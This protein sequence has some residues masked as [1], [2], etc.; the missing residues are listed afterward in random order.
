MK[1]EKYGIIYKITNKVNGKLYIGQTIKKDGFNGRYRGRGEGIERVWNTYKNYLNGDKTRRGFNPHLVSAIRKYGFDAFIVEEEFDVAYSQEE[2]NE[3][4][5]YWIEYYNSANYDKGYNISLG[6]ELR[7]DE[8]ENTIAAFLSILSFAKKVNSII[9]Y[10]VDND[11]KITLPKR[12]CGYF[13]YIKD[14][15]K[16]IKEGKKVKN[17]KCCGKYFITK[18]STCEKCI[19]VVENKYL[20]LEDDDIVKTIKDIIKHKE[21]YLDE[22]CDGIYYRK[23]IEKIEKMDVSKGINFTDYDIEIINSFKES[24]RIVFALLVL[25][26]INKEQETKISEVR[27]LIRLSNETNDYVKQLISESKYFLVNGNNFTVV[28]SQDEK[29]KFAIYTLENLNL[30]YKYHFKYDQS[31]YDICKKCKLPYKKGKG[32]KYCKS[33]ANRK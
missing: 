28:K 12:S 30:Q 4:E 5:M 2:L 15:S 1:K 16:H 18:G 22:K 26:K 17:C 7:R 19:E 33:C 11:I 14:V 3:K 9:D 8:Y 24:N 32:T 6:G 29:N 21:D 20:L 27:D 31:L 10:V 23:M 13:D 25:Y